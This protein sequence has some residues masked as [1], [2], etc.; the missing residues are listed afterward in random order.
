MEL[1]GNKIIITGATRG[2]GLALTEA[3]YALDN[4]I[5]AVAR[6]TT[7]LKELKATYPKIDIL[8]CDLS[9]Q[10]AIDNLVKEIHSNHSDTNTLINNA[11]IQVNFYNHMFGQEQDQLNK[12]KEEIQVNFTAIVALTFQLIPL[13]MQNSNASIVNVSSGLGFVPKKSAPVYCGTKA[14]VHIFT[15]SLRYQYEHTHVKVFEIIPPLV[16]TDMTQERGKDKL[17]PQALV[18]QFIKAYQSDKYEINIGKTKLLR[19][20]QRIAPSL[21]DRILKNK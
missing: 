12:V 17:T 13:L 2:I 14:A 20:L 4:H 5:V 6:N 9:N 1:K 15:K 3:L 21:A 8:S 7:R 11:G 19:I 16:D 18:K 10:K